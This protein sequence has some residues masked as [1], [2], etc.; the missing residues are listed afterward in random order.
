MVS[1][2]FCANIG[3]TM[4]IA[5]QENKLNNFEVRADVFQVNDNVDDTYRKVLKYVKDYFGE[6]NIMIGKDSHI[7][8]KKGPKLYVN[9]ASFMLRLCELSRA[10]TLEAK[11]NSWDKKSDS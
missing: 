8:V 2:I 9:R 5:V 4:N 11:I 7:I 3:K 1:Y 10:A 6:E